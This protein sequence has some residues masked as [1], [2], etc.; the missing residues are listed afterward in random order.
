[1]S[2]LIE[3]KIYA[4]TETSLDLEKKPLNLGCIMTG[5]R[6]ASH[7]SFSEVRDIKSV[8]VCVRMREREREK[9]RTA[10]FLL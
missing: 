7:S 6:A 8:S 9:E 2:L 3:R 5:A 1:M 10:W 4:S